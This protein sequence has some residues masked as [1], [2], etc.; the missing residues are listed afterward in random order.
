MGSLIQLRWAY[1][2]TIFMYSLARA[3]LAR[4]LHS[5][6]CSDYN[7][8]VCQQRN[9]ASGNDSI[10]LDYTNCSNICCTS[11]SKN[12]DESQQ[13]VVSETQSTTEV[14]S[15]SD[16]G[17]RTTSGGMTWG[18][19]GKPK[20]KPK[21]K[22]KPKPKGKPKPK[23]KPAVK[24]KPKP[25]SKN[26]QWN[27][28]SSEWNKPSSE[29]IESKPSGQANSKPTTPVPTPSP[30]SIPTTLVTS[31]PTSISVKSSDRESCICSEYTSSQCNRCINGSLTCDNNCV[32]QCCIVCDCRDYPNDI[33]QAC[34]NGDFKCETDC[35]QACCS[36]KTSE[37]SY[38]AEGTSYKENDTTNNKNDSSYG[39]YK[40]NAESESYKTK[41][42]ASMSVAS[43]HSKLKIAISFAVVA[44]MIAFIIVGFVFTKVR[45]RL[46]IC[47]QLKIV[48]LIYVS[49]FAISKEQNV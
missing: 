31:V 38:D 30:T 34:Q 26:G 23:S 28:P 14:D 15:Q 22:P 11:D 2:A 19:E 48:F 10:Q 3:E 42:N 35:V 32:E 41:P 45:P 24:A 47:H 9:D 12:E 4:E 5:C 6:D 25:S 20:S 33:C 13:E 18:Y 21:S 27:K 49:T 8:S 44:L 1:I 29:W 39:G 43:N 7:E 16:W 40:Y 36:Q 37:N 17:G 46:D